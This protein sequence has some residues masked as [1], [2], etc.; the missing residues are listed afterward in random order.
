MDDP[1]VLE[2]WNIVFTQYN[3]SVH[4][5]VGIH[6]HVFILSSISPLGYN[7]ICKWVCILC[8]WGEWREKLIT[9]M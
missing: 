9:Y 8:C 6:V 1:D 7:I 4:Q 2:I 3:K 5:S